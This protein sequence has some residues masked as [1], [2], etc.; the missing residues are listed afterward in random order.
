MPIYISRGRSRQ[1]RSRACWLSQKTGA[2]EQEV[3]YCHSLLPNQKVAERLARFRRINL[4]RA[5]V[6][7]DALEFPQRKDRSAR[8]TV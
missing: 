6:H 2:F 3:E 5:S 4:Q 7:H 8:P 1:R